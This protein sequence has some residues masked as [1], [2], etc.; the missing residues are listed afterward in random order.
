MNW[1][2]NPFPYK[3]IN[4]L[5]DANIISK[6]FLVSSTSTAVLVI[7][8]DRASRNFE[9]DLYGKEEEIIVHHDELSWQQKALG[10]AKVN[11][12]RLIMGSWVASLAGSWILVSRD[13][14]LTG[15]QKIVQARMYAQGATLAVLLISGV[16]ASRDMKD[17]NKRVVTQV[18]DPAHPG[19]KLSVEHAHG[20]RYPG[21]NA[22][23]T[24]IAEQESIRK[25]KEEEAGK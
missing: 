14:Y 12:W 16:L 25:E 23:E 3:Y 22:W 1:F 15:A 6:T 19:K 4:T 9:N 18:D 10:W 21:E 7:E 2:S 24:M 11:R 5:G 13:K 8:G 20:E 17:E